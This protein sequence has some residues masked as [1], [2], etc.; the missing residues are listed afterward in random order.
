M[1]R[2]EDLR[3]EPRSGGRYWGRTAAYVAEKDLSPLR[4]FLSFFVVFSWGVS[5]RNQ[6]NTK[7]IEPLEG[8][9]DGIDSTT[10]LSRLRRSAHRDRLNSGAHATRA[11]SVSCIPQYGAIRDEPRSGGRYWGRTAAYV[12]EKDLSPLRGFLSFLSCFPGA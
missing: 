9:T 2:L 11:L 10:C 12:A 6:K 8:A 1:T 3:P 7:I 4:G 5:P